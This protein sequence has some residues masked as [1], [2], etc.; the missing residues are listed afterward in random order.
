VYRVSRALF[1]RYLPEVSPDDP[2]PVKLFSRVDTRQ[3]RL[4]THMRLVRHKPLA[5]REMELFMEIDRL[6]NY[7]CSSWFSDMGA[8]GYLNTYTVLRDLWMVGLGL[9]RA[10][11]KK[12]C[13]MGDPFAWTGPPYMSDRLPSMRESCIFV[14]ENMIMTSRDIEFRRLGALYF[15]TAITC[16]SI[17]ARE[18]M[19][20]L[21][22]SVLWMYHADVPL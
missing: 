12:I 22:E 4:R 16:V 21:Y 8:D 11:R 5:E 13:P 20:W 18:R 10:T 17:P 15:L 14:A 3:L 2:V 7:S 9:S 1:S 6:G 19:P